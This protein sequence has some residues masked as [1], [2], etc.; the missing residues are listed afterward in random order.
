L[1]PDRKD[2]EDLQ[3]SGRPRS[4]T[5]QEDKKVVNQYRGCWRKKSM[6]RRAIGQELKNPESKMPKISGDTA[7]RRLQEAGGEM[8]VKQKRFPLTD[9]HKRLRVKFVADMKKENFDYGCGP[10]KQ[11]SKLGLESEKCFI[12]L[13]K[14]WKKRN[15]DIPSLKKFGPV[16]GDLAR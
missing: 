4:T 13:E 6:G 9:R 16:Q 14:N 7:Y 3:R 8:K 10:T 15:S 12:F 2:G 5:P 1:D 11:I